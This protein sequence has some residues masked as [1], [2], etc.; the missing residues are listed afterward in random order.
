MTMRIKG[1]T[2]SYTDGDHSLLALDG[3]DLTLSPGRITAL[4]GESGSGKTTLGKALIG[5]LPEN[6][7]I[8]GRVCLDGSDILELSEKERNRYRWQRISMVFQDGQA[9]LNPVMRI[10]D[11]IAEP[12]IR[13]LG[14]GRE[15]AR[16]AV[17]RRLEEVGLDAGLAKRYPHELSG[18]QAQRVLLAM[19]LVLDPE[20]LILD[21]PT[22]ALDATTKNF[23]FSLLRDLKAGGRSLLL[24]THDLELVSGVS[25]DVAVL[26]LGQ[27]MEAMPA[28]ELLTEPMHPYSSA[29]VRSFPGMDTVRDLGGIRGDAFYRFT[30][31][32]S[33]R[34]GSVHEHTH[35]KAPGTV[36]EGGH[37]PL[38]G[39]LFEPRCTQAIPEC[40]TGD[41]GFT[42]AGSHSVRC[43]RGGIVAML[44]MEGVC[45]SYGSVQ[46]LES[47]D[48][49]LK[50][51]EVF[52]IVGETG[53]GKT[54]LAMVAAAALGPDRG[55]R[56][57]EGRDMDL[58]R[59]QD[60][61]SLARRIGIIYQNPGEAVSH[62]F[63]VFDIVAEPLR[64]QKASF[65]PEEIRNRVVSAL[66]EVRLS[67]APEFLKRY[68]HELNMGAIQRLCIARA[69]IHDPVMLIADE[70][71]SSLDPSVQA[72][73]LKLLLGLQ[74]EKGLTM[75]FVTHDL[76]IARKV[77]DR[78]AV[79]LA[80]RVVESGPAKRIVNHPSHPYTE[81]L[82]ESAKG[83]AAPSLRIE[84]GG[85]Q[86]EGICPFLHRC[87]FATERCRR[88]YPE[89]AALDGGHHLVWCWNPRRSS[90]IMDWTQG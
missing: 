10:S 36:H 90:S 42:A 46:A 39:C 54:T 3:V 53:S 45:K 81:M 38:E 77:A 67:S 70:P 63:S 41:V 86:D 4:V 56:L 31:V 57:F 74:I 50:A 71:T 23:V 43:L 26:Y 79:M 58:W 64:I 22:A 85:N 59:R 47:T 78:I 65:G 40:R 30:H 6:A 7:R 76:G 20:Y 18:G 34:D 8:R 21:E 66:N 62:R 72:K 75:L 27:I 80:G 5:L 51:G 29:L 11:Q 33:H 19:A 16:P 83:T 24:I 15:E 32:H 2:V 28:G 82:V 13:R 17:Q 14:Y 9:G 88:R 48:L 84:V 37:A 44:V 89:V 87:R 61:R 55:S 1:L 25:D 60:Y 52:C 69:L 68:P 49:T 12:L 35:V 73:V